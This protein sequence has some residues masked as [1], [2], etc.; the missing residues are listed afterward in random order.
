MDWLSCTSIFACHDAKETVLV[1][2]SNGDAKKDL[3]IGVTL[4]GVAE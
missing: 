1:W 3:D 4:L 2:F